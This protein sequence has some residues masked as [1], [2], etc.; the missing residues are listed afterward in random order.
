MNGTTGLA[1]IL[2]VCAL[3]CF[4]IG[5]MSWQIPAAPRRALTWWVGGLFFLLLSFMLGG[6]T[7]WLHPIGAGR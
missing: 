6:A 1:L 7:F 3:V 4:F 5:W 2:Q